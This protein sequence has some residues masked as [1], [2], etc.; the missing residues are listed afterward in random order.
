[1]M[2]ASNPHQYFLAVNNNINRNGDVVQSVRNALNVNGQNIIG[3][4][5]VNVNVEDIIDAHD[6]SCWKESTYT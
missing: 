3:L 1:M 4:N 2:Y 6:R 5:L